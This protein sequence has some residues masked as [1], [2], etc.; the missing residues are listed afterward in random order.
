MKL[1][2][3]APLAPRLIRGACIPVRPRTLEGRSGSE[4]DASAA[5]G[6]PL[7]TPGIIAAAET[8][9]KPFFRNSRRSLFMMQIFF[10]AGCNLL[11]YI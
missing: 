7:I 8:P 10:V 1:G 4:A 6:E 11:S 9:S 2:V 3:I 5:A